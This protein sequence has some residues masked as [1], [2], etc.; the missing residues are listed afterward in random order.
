MKKEKKTDRISTFI[1]ADACIDGN[2]EF[3]G[4]IRVDGQV[5]GKIVSSGGTVVVGEKADVDAELHVNVAVVM[6][7]VKGKVEAKERIEV[8]PPGRVSGDIQAPVISIEPGGIFNGSCVMKASA[9]SADKSSFFSK[10]Q[11]A[12]S[13]PESQPSTTDPKE[14]PVLKE[15]KSN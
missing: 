1:G 9:K 2:I 3:K 14:K 6:G 7:D 5:K 8:Y 4:T 13:D 15:L 10:K 11:P 12:P